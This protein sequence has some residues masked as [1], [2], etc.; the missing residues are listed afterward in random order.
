[1]QG[2]ASKGRSWSVW[3][4]IIFVLLILRAVARF[5]A[6]TANLN[7]GFEELALMTGDVALLLLILGETVPTIVIW[8]G[9]LAVPWTVE[10]GSAVVSRAVA[11]NGAQN[12][13]QAPALVIL[14]TSVL[15]LL[16]MTSSILRHE[17]DGMTES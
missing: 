11:G 7:A 5:G 17:G 9:A 12:M 3:T 15:L 10:L 16:I 1:M 14:G 6:I 4:Q 8:I 2:A 13:S